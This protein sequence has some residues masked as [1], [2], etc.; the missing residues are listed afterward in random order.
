MTKSPF[1]E[2]LAQFLRQTIDDL[3][4]VLRLAAVGDEQAVL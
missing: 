3:L 1:R 2:L 4:D